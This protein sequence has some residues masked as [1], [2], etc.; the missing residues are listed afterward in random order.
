MWEAARSSTRGSGWAASGPASLALGVPRHPE[1]PGTPCGGAGADVGQCPR[2]AFWPCRPAARGHGEHDR[3][4]RGERRVGRRRRRR[5]HRAAHGPFVSGLNVAVEAASAARPP[6]AAVGPRDR[7]RRA[8][9]F[10]AAELL[11]LAAPLRLRCR[12]Q[13]LRV[14]GEGRRRRRRGGEWWRDGDGGGAHDHH[15]ELR[16]AELGGGGG[17]GAEAGGE[18]G[19]H[20]GGD[21]GG[22]HADGGGDDHAAFFDTDRDERWRDSG[23]G[24]DAALQARSVAVVADA[25]WTVK[26]RGVGDVGGGSLEHPRQWLGGQWTGLSRLGSAEAPRATRHALRRRRSRRRAVPKGG[27]LAM[28]PCR[29]RSW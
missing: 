24:G 21:G 22:R 8:T 6:A 20:R 15:D 7:R 4:E 2:E 14:A 17:G 12:P 1:P 10:Q 16:G 5:R 29:S 19:A 28:P 13:L 3:L 27:V 18:R 26:G 9:T 11:V 23:D 25:A